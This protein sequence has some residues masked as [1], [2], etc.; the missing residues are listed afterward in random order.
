[1]H[2]YKAMGWVTDESWFKCCG[3]KR[4]FSSSEHLDQLWGPP[5]LLVKGYQG[6]FTLGIK[7]LGHEADHSPTSSVEIKNES[8]TEF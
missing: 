8:D 6:L 4:F 5:S 3:S 1:M 7:R 2:S